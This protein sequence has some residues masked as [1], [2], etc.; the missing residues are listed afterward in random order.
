[1]PQLEA[2]RL[3]RSVIS[4]NR[5][6]SL[7]GP[8]KPCTSAS[9]ETAEPRTYCRM[10]RFTTCMLQKRSTEA[11]KFLDVAMGFT[12]LDSSRKLLRIF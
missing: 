12:H 8:K 6:G 2:H 7:P 10:P 5:S 1:M 11:S 4:V 3:N 9:K